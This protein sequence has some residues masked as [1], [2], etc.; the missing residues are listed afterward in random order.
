MPVALTRTEN[1]V[2]TNSIVRIVALTLLFVPLTCFGAE[3][4]GHM[5]V[6]D[7]AA[8]LVGLSTLFS[9]IN[10]RVFHLPSTIGLVVISLAASLTVGWFARRYRSCP[11]LVVTSVEIHVGDPECHFC[12]RSIFDYCARPDRGT[13]D[14]EGDPLAKRRMFET[15]RR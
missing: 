6:F 15:I 11:G 12:R 10:Y 7:I 9:Y 3:A 1:T 4:A 5:N 14:S 8:V 2:K 13:F